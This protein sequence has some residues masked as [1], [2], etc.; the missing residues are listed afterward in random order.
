MLVFDG[1]EEVV[2]NKQHH[3]KRVHLL[4]FNGAEVMEVTNKQPPPKMSALAR[5]RWQRGG[6][7]GK[8][9]D[10]IK[11]EQMRSFSMVQR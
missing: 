10:T 5:F 6:G 2:V 3:R 9:A 1:E 11:N 7:G 4:V 8:Q